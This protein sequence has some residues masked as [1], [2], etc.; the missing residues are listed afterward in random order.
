M[1]LS[2]TKAKVG[3]IVS[4]THTLF[5][6]SCVVKAHIWGRVR[7]GISLSVGQVCLQMS[8]DTSIKALCVVEQGNGSCISTVLWGQCILFWYVLFCGI[9]ILEQTV[10]R[11]NSLSM[12]IG[13]QTCT[14]KHFIFTYHATTFLQVYCVYLWQAQ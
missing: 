12:G 9:G 5:W 3:I 1:A 10:G 6:C 13:S 7:L 11:C 4:D 8:L 2:P 14:H